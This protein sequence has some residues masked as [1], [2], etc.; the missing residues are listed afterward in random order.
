MKVLLINK[1]LFFHFLIKIIFINQRNQQ[2]M[3]IAADIHNLMAMIFKKNLI[4]L[5]YKYVCCWNF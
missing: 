2:C 1:Y 5:P 4:S 3:H